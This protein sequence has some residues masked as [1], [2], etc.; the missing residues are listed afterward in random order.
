MLACSLLSALPTEAQAPPSSKATAENYAGE[1]YVIEQ[2]KNTVRFEADG[3]GKHEML[4]RV[5]IQSESAVREFGLLVYPF[6]ASFQTLDVVYARVRK[7]NGSVVDTPAADIQELDSAVSREAPMYTDQREKHIAVKSLAVGDTLDLDLL[8]TFH[9]PIAPGHFWYDHNFVDEGICLDET[10]ELNVPTSVPVKLAAP[11]FSPE[12]RQEGDRRIYVFHSSHLEKKRE[13]GPKSEDEIPAWEKN[14]HGIDPPAV[15][16]SSFTSW[17]DVGTWYGGLQ[18]PRIQVT[19]RIRS[20]AEEITKGKATEEEKIRAIYD[21][22]STRFRY[23]GIDLG[24]GRYTPHAAE[25]VLGNR[26]G[27]CKDKHTLFAALLEAV[28]VHAYPALISSNF[29]EDPAMPSPSLFDHVITAIPRGNSFLFLDTTPEVAPYGLL[30]QGLRDRQ[31][32]VIPTNGPATLVTTP[33]DGPFLNTEKFKMDATIDYKGTLDGKVHLEDRGDTEVLLRLAYRNTPQ[34]SW[35]ELTQGVVARLGFGGTVSN[36]ASAEPEKADGPFWITYDYHRKDYPDWENHR[37]TLPF[38][39]LF[40]P[41]LNDAQ[42]KSKDPLPLGSPQDIVYETSLKLPEGVL[43]VVPPNADLKN[44]FG[45][46]SATYSFEKGILRGKRHLTIKLREVSG[47]ERG[48]YST[49]TKAIR[50]DAERWIFLGGNF[51]IASPVRKAQALLHEGKAAE[52]VPLLEKAAGDDPD[53]QEIAYALGAAYARTDNAE[54]AAEQ[55]KKLLS[56][57]PTATML[58]GAA[59][60]LSNANVRLDDALDYASRAVAQT[61]EET[62]NVRLISAVTADYLRMKDLATE[63]DTVGWIKFRKGD[64]AG[65]E[66][67]IRAAWMLWQ[68]ALIGEHL[69]EVYEK[70][71]RKREADHL[72]TLALAAPGKDDEPF[73]RG[74]LE[75]MQK[76]LGVTKP[77]NRTVSARGY[78]PPPFLGG[79]ELSEMRA[80]KVRRIITISKGAKSAIFAVAIENGKSTAEARFVSGDK[81]LEVEEDSLVRTNFGALFPD[82]VPAKILRAGWLSCSKYSSECTMVF[83]QVDDSASF[84]MATPKPD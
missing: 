74:K 69:A 21:Y 84:V 12:V 6:M 10:L 52:A 81:D 43:P 51:E 36:V 79:I 35:T 26:Y 1:P 29:K 42:K 49:F 59:Y 50:D 8:W 9:D 60:E 28:G 38:P 71:G 11:K 32:L 4:L 53:N 33:A 23:I 46:Y 65:A 68:H 3:K 82:E 25:D 67:Y 83:F 73:L 48:S 20:T 58:N 62:M 34:N 78:H 31:A 54:K 55:F 64:A 40:L 15:R 30:L 22:V 37:I 2:L 47:E 63:W 41:E 19:P 70:L 80:V 77:E 17:A 61:S 18:Q 75:E 45:E 5:R 66:K 56:G 39:P 44:D 13:N 16:L 57:K 72:C 24:Y 7:A 14:V 76:R 27:D